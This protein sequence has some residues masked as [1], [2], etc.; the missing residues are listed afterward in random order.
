[1]MAPDLLEV[2]RCPETRQELHPADVKLVQDL[3][4]RI[5]KSALKNR[6]GQPVAEPLDDG[7][8]RAD[9]KFLYPLRKNLPVMLIDEAI[10]LMA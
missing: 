3:N 1:M 4:R 2:L 5:A 6:A 7:L 8:L 10:P 9:G